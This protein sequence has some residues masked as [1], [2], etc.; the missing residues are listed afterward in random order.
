MFSRQVWGIMPVLDCRPL[1]K[2]CNDDHPNMLMDRQQKSTNDASAIFPSIPIGSA[3]AVQSE[4]GRP[5]THWTIVAM[6]NHNHHN[7][8]H[9]QWQMHHT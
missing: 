3:V 7:M 6:S 5:W 8:T 2:D 1:I 9:N 4:D